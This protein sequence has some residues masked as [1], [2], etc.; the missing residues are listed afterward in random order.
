MSWTIDFNEC[1]GGLSLDDKVYLDS[2]LP[3]NIE[4]V[5]TEDTNIETR[6]QDRRVVSS[7]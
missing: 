6:I 5:E 1:M 7:V 4:S 2:T 3:D